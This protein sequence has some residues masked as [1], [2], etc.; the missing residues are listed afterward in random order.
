MG[1][2]EPEKSASVVLWSIAI[3]VLILLATLVGHCQEQTTTWSKWGAAPFASSQP[4][5]CKKASAAIDGFKWPQ[6]VK[7]HFK[8]VACK[9]G[10]TAWLTPGTQLDQMWSGGPKPHVMNGIAVAD[11][12]VLKSPDGRSYHKGAVAES[13]KA[14]AWS[15]AYEG[16]TYVLYLPEVCFNW[17]WAFGPTPAPP[18]IPP[19]ALPVEKC[20]EISFNAPPGKV[21]WGVASANGPLPPSVC[22][23]QKQGDGPWTAW[24]G[25]CDECTGAIEY[26]RGILGDKAEVYHK[27][28]YSVYGTP[29]VRQPR[30]FLRFSEAVRAD[31]V[32]I[33]LEDANGVRT[34]GVYV[35]PQDWDGKSVIGI[36]DSFWVQDDSGIISIPDPL[37]VQGGSCPE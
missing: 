25:Q 21:R 14:L 26:I 30:Q 4:E 16:R 10:E 6:P 13:A 9:G 2:N 24:T 3:G 5:A 23:A 7:E 12:P 17:S 37:W 20:V 31:V 22:N 18:A 29:E 28:L 8:E 11:L 1:S 34:C 36:S 27:Y 35:R 32:Y 33:C 15:W 19:P